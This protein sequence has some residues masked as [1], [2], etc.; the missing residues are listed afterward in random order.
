MNEGYFPVATT[1]SKQMKERR[2]GL[3]E[4][5][6]NKKDPDVADVALCVW[7]PRSKI[8]EVAFCVT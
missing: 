5:K 1:L 4:S 6:K 8:P 3:A 7:Y 2:E